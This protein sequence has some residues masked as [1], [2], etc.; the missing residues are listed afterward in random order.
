[1]PAMKL[2]IFDL[3]EEMKLATIFHAVQ[4]IFI[5]L[6]KRNILYRML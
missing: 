5:Y 3:E 2:F 6:E 4:N 1:M